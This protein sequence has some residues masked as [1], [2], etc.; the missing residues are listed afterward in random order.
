MLVLVHECLQVCVWVCVLVWVCLLVGLYVGGVCGWYV[1]VPRGTFP[2]IS[3]N[4][5]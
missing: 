2:Q 1:H 5:P 3:L 4:I